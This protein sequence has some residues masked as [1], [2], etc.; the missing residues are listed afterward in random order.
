M[1][2]KDNKLV[3]KIY[4]GENTVE[5]IYKGTDKVYE[6]LPIGYRE[7]KYIESTGTQYI[8]TGVK[9]N[10]EIKIDTIFEITN[11]KQLQ[12]FFGS[13]QS[14]SA[15]TFCFISVSSTNNS[16]GFRSDFNNKM[17]QYQTENISRMTGY[18][19]FH[20]IKNKNVT[21]IE[22]NAFINDISYGSF[23]SNYNIYIFTVN[24]NNTASSNFSYMKLY[25]FKVFKNDILIQNLIPCLDNN[26]VPCFY[27]SVNK[28]TH[29]NRGT[30]TFGYELL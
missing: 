10:S 17:G 13:R 20:V 21:T 18:P 14:V 15:Q 7:C 2:K 19:L 4:D 22:N 27:D 30:G 3:C 28:Q 12:F 5:R 11:T 25:S 26:D 8:D 24:N 9:G 6:Y 23:T 29:Y 1:I 16:W